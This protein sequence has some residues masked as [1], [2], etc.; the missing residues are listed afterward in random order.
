MALQIKENNGV[1]ILEGAINTTTAQSLKI[2]MDTMLLNNEEVTIHI[3]KVN[4]ID[5]AGLSILRELYT[6][7]KRDNQAFYIIGYGCKDLYHDF[8][9]NYAA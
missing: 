3:G 8:R 4:E 2:H 9:T 1:F 5:R 6:N 7:S